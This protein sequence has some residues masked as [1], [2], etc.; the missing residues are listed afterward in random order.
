M[1][2][3]DG[4][5]GDE[6]VVIGSL[7]LGVEGLDGEPVDQDGIVRGAQRHGV[8]PA[9]GGGGALAAFADGLTMFLQFG[10]LQVFSNRLMRSW[11]AGEDEVAAGILDGGNDRLAGKQIVAEIDRPEVSEVGAVPGQPPFRGIALA[12]L[13]LRPIL[14]RDK[15]RRQGQDLLVARCDHA[16]TQEGVEVFGAAIGAP[17]CR[18]LLAF[19]LA[20]T[21]V[22]APIER[23][24]HPPVKTLERCQWPR[25]LDRLHEQSV[26]CR[27]RSAVQ[28]QADVVVGGD[29]RHAEQRL[30]VRP[31]VPLRQRLLMPKERRA[32]HE[33]DRKR[34]QTNVRH[35]VVAVAPRASA[36]VVQTGADF[37]QRPDHVC[38]GAHPRP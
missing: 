23:D 38:N 7:A 28:H 25:C 5:I 22:L 17:P 16:G 20:R 32:S 14:R 30:A 34:R 37:A 24:R 27:R 15:F 36:L 6:A 18:T 35:C 33:E 21:E 13:L 3:C 8:E 12:V 29:R 1:S 31:T 11:L 19:D 10:A 26:E 4:E 9:V 2:A